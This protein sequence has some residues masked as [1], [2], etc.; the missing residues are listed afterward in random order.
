MTRTEKNRLK[1]TERFSKPTQWLDQWIM[2]NHKND[3]H[4][5]L[6]R[7]HYYNLRQTKCRDKFLDGH[8]NNYLLV[9]ERDREDEP[10]KIHLY[11][12]PTSSR[13]LSQ[14]KTTLMWEDPELFNKLSDHIRKYGKCSR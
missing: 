3:V 8:R 10:G 6:C 12:P 9:I 11:A 7:G 4:V 14:Y 13:T 1:L 2:A 5:C